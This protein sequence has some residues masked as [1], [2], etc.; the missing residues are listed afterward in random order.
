M[1]SLLELQRRFAAALLTPAPPADP[2]LATYRGTVFANWRNALGAT[3]V[4]VRELTGAPFFA[5]AVD[6]FARTHPSRGGDLNVYG[7]VFPD[8]LATYPP[9][10]GLPYLA[11]VA[12]LEWANYKELCLSI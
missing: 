4:V 8:F 9:A 3:F 11:D 10:Q 1:P 2:G 6:A 5:A 12:R 7:D